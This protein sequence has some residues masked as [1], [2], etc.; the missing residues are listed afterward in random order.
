MILRRENQTSPEHRHIYTGNL[1][2]VYNFHLGGGGMWGVEGRVGVGWGGSSEIH[3]PAMQD[4]PKKRNQTSPEHRHI[5]TGN[6]GYFWNIT[7]FTD[8]RIQSSIDVHWR[9]RKLSLRVTFQLANNVADGG[10]KGLDLMLK[11]VPMINSFSHIPAQNN[12]VASL[13]PSLFR[14][15]GS[16]SHRKANIS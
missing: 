1:R 9:Q 16:A 4:D 3:K 2:Y 14:G 15:Q 6:L 10:S 7:V 5:Y 13:D 12:H 8:N 11:W